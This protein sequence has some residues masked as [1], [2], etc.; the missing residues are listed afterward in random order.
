MKGKHKMFLWLTDIDYTV[1]LATLYSPC[2]LSMFISMHTALLIL[3]AG[4]KFWASGASG[5][6]RPGIYRQ[7]EGSTTQYTLLGE[8]DI[9]SGHRLDEE[10][11]DH[12]AT[13]NTFLA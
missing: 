1:P 4:W 11:D 8:T 2:R 5:G 7:V 10:V 9:P 12:E 3:F 13:S 6:L